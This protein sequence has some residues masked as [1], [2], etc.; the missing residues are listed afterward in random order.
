MENRKQMQQKENIRATGSRWV[1]WSFAKP[2]DF[3]F[4]YT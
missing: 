1:E 3:I 4:L 2:N